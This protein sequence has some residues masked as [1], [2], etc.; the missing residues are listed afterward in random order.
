MCL[1]IKEMMYETLHDSVNW[2]TNTSLSTLE[3][4]LADNLPE[5]KLFVLE[6]LVL[7]GKILILLYTIDCHCQSPLS[8][9]RETSRPALVALN[10]GLS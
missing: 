9:K 1:G 5:L 3:Q 7:F 2:K 6:N 8:S 4:Y 10:S